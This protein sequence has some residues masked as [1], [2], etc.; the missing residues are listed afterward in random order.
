MPEFQWLPWI[1]TA[2]SVFPTQWWF[3]A[4]LRNLK[5]GDMNAQYKERQVFC[6]ILSLLR[7]YNPKPL[8]YWA[9]ITTTPMC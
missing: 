5:D 7:V 2:K 6:Q 8:C 4:A 3:L 9:M 1:E